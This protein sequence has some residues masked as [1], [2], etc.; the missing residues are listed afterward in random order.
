[1]LTPLVAC[2]GFPW[3]KAYVHL[4]VADASDEAE[5]ENHKKFC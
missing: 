2:P 3:S 1:M 4:F 5:D